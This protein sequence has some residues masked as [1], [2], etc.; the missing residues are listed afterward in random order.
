MARAFR[1]RSWRVC[2][3][4]CEL[5]SKRACPSTPRLPDRGSLL[6]EEASRRLG[7]V[8]K[9]VGIACIPRFSHCRRRFLSHALHSCSRAA[10]KLKR[11][12]RGLGSMRDCRRCRQ[13]RKP[14]KSRGF[15]R[16]AFHFRVDRDLNAAT[17]I[18]W[19]R[20]IAPV[21]GTRCDGW[22]VGARRR[23]NVLWHFGMELPVAGCGV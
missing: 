10:L 23:A 21:P 22:G 7:N 6:A 19:P 15:R 12:C 14:G 8:P 4:S 16:C 20:K 18:R 5:D 9:Q 3:R 1:H 11:H 2:D 17:N 13:R